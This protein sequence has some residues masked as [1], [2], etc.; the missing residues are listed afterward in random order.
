[1]WLKYI[2]P[3]IIT[4][5]VQGKI[6]IYISHLQYLYQNSHFVKKNA[7]LRYNKQ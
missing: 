3:N 5:Y 1:M 2:I 6:L 7:D 4:P